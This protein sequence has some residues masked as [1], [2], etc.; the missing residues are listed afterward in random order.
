MS[1]SDEFLDEGLAFWQSRTNQALTREDVRQM[2]ENL[3]GFFTVLHDWVGLEDPEKEGQS[4][5]NKGTVPTS[6][7]DAKS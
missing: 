5:D 6:R 2:V 1:L 3:C 7:L 4:V